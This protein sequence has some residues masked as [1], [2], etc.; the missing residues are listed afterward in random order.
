[1]LIYDLAVV[2]AKAA[3]KYPLRKILAK[4]L[5]AAFQQVSAHAA[6]IVIIGLASKLCYALRQSTFVKRLH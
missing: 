3:S 5:E 1:M 4:D 6:G 2:R